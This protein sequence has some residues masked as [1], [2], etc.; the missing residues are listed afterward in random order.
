MS[1]GPKVTICVPAY[2][3]EHTI[4]TS[5]ASALEQ[6]FGDFE[7]LVVDNASTDATV[8]RVL[9]LDDGRIRV[10]RNAENI[11]PIA[12]HNRCIKQAR[13]D[14]IQF[15]HSDDRLLPDCL[16]RLVPSFSD[17]RVG[18]AFARRQIESSDPRWTIWIGTLHTPLEPLAGINDGMSIVRRYVDRGSK[19]NWIGEPTSVMIRRSALMEVGGFN[20]RQRSYSDMELWLRILARYDAA[21]VDAELSVRVQHEDTLTAL[22]EDT[23]EAWLDRPW[24]LAALAHDRHLDPG[25]RSKAWRQWV[26]AALKKAVR[27]QQAPGDLRRT[28]YKQLSRHVRES[29][30]WD[31]SSSTTSLVVRSTA[32]SGV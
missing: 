25:I 23:D 10:L 5:I 17:H 22:Y 19:G 3:C 27:A 28:K 24:I 18:L 21:W 30:V 12:N 4:E 31:S 14:L 1:V 20:T 26:V 13:G 6:S 16:S 9:S 15:L 29:L 11:G 2:N 8:D 32:G 7:C